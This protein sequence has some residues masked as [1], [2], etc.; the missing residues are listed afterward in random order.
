MQEESLRDDP[1]DR[2]LMGA[3]FGAVASLHAAVEQP[4]IFDRLFLQSG[5]FAFTDI[6]PHD[7]RRSSILSCAS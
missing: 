7:R 6:G 5:S 2:C 3:S 1:E 4:G